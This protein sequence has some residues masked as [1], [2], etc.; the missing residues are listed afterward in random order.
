MTRP[1][2][3]WP[4]VVSGL[5]ISTVPVPAAPIS[6]VEFEAFVASLLSLIVIPSASSCPLMVVVPVELSTY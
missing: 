5:D 2:A 4:K 6:N 1:V 3:V